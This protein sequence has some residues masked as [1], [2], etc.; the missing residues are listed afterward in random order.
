MVSQNQNRISL[1][2]VILKEGGDNSYPCD[3]NKVLYK[4]GEDLT[5]KIGYLVKH[6]NS[7][8]LKYKKF[9]LSMTLHFL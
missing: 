7:R 1:G 3:D 2:K 8:I 9:T 6:K 5:R 4:R